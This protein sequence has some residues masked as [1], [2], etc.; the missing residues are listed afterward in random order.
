MGEPQSF[1]LTREDIAD[2]V[3]VLALS[4]EADHP[5]SEAVC[6]EIESARCEGRDVIVDLTAANHVDPPMVAALVGATEE[7]RRRG[8]PALIV[9]AGEGV[10]RSLQL[11]GLEPILRVAG[12]REGAIE[13]LAGG[14]A[15]D[16]VQHRAAAVAAHHVRRVGH[17]GDRGV[18]AAVRAVRAQLEAVQAGDAAVAPRQVR[19]AQAI[20]PAAGADRTGA[21]LCPRLGHRIL[22]RGC[23]GG[24]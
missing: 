22:I 7:G 11:K 15:P 5:C 10:R 19:R 17:A 12:T 1:Q 18:V 8:E 23:A 2:G 24:R 13:L 3:S 16:L 9:C 20:G 6:A 14:A 4:G 21:R